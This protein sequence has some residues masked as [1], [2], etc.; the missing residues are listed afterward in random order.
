MNEKLQAIGTYKATLRN[1]S[2]GIDECREGIHNLVVDSGLEAMLNAIMTGGTIEPITH[3]VIGDGS[4]TVSSGDSALDNEVGRK[5]KSLQ[6]IAGA[7]GYISV[8]FGYNEANTTIRE[9]GV[10]VDGVDTVGG[11]GTL[12]SRVSEEHP[13]LPLTKQN[14]QTLTID[15]QL[16]LV[17]G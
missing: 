14:T 12:F 17:S 10:L 2:G 1:R 6:S 8:T 3:I 4:A 5:P 16:S 11:A 13:K 7:T 15:Y 9:F